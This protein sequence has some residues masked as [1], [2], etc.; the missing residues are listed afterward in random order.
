[1]EVLR[2]SKTDPLYTAVPL[3]YRVYIVY[4]VYISYFAM[5]ILEI[6]R[7]RGIKVYHFL[8]KMISECRAKNVKIYIGHFVAV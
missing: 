1:M 8:T 6:L 3:V 2:Y 4:I 5:S 7:C